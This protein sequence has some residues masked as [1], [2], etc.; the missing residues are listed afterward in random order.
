MGAARL[1][2]VH[3]PRRVEDL[4]GTDP[5]AHEAEAQAVAGSPS[6]TGDRPPTPNE[7]VLVTEIRK[8]RSAI[9]DA[10]LHVDDRTLTY[11]ATMDDE[12]EHAVFDPMPR[13]EL[14]SVDRGVIVSGR[15]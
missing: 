13:S 2:I 10:S 1:K 14:H 7:L 12:C 15:H 8:D 5:P 4:A 9:D 11:Q 6:A 3:T